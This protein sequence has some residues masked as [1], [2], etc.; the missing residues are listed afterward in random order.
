MNSQSCSLFDS[1]QEIE[2]KP[3]TP[4]IEASWLKVLQDEFQKPYFQELKE[5]LV[6]EIKSGKKIFPPPSQIFS[7]FDFCPFDNVKVVILGQDPYHGTG[8]AHGLCFSV[9]KQVPIP[10]SLQ[11]IYKE[12]HDDLGLPIP[13][14]GNL[15]SWARQGVLLLNTTLTVQKS[16]PMSHAGKGWEEFTDRVIQEISDR[17]EGVV[18]LLW[19]RHAQT[20]GQN[21]DRNKHSV[22]TA[23]HPSPFSVHSGFFGCKHFS[24]TNE[25]LKKLEKN[26]I[27]WEI[28]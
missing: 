17:K 14:H 20:K 6:Q 2:K 1:P 22:L 3:A 7:A 15:E 13:S 4:K 12:I 28:G 8:Q 24:Q 26:P 23:P 11:N 19:G 18:F 9:N 25:I 16:N 5:F 27:N 21:I 10:P